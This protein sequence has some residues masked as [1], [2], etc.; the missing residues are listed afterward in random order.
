MDNTPKIRDTFRRRDALKI[1]PVTLPATAATVYSDTEALEESIDLY[2]LTAKGARL[3]DME[4]NISIPD[5]TVAQMVDAD[6]LTFSILT[7]SVRPI[8]AS[9]TVVA[10]DC[11]VCTG[12]GG[13]G[14]GPLNHRFKIPSDCQRYIGVKIVHA[15]TG[16]P[17]TAEAI[18]ELLF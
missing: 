3:E 13:V 14:V 10:G 9:S 4:L 6:T 7:D 12:A 5:L 2:P 17:E 18:T 1:E 8:D 16:S 15:G 11:F